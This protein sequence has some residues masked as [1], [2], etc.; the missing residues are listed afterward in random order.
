MPDFLFRRERAGTRP[1]PYA[2]KENSQPWGWEYRGGRPSLRL[3]LRISPLKRGNSVSFKEGE[4][5]DLVVGGLVLGWW[6]VP[7]GIL[8]LCLF[9]VC[10]RHAHSVRGAV[11]PCSGLRRAPTAPFSL[12]LASRGRFGDSRPYMHGCTHGPRRTDTPVPS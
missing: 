1:A 6:S 3:A 8:S 4:I 10:K 11:S 2:K 9:Y 7:L 12:S 5:E